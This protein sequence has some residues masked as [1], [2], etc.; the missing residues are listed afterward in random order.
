[1]K[2]QIIIGLGSGRC[3][4]VSL[5]RLLNSQNDSYFKHES[6]PIVPWKFDQKII[7]NKL[8]LLSKKKC[9]Y[10]G[11][12]S[13]S[14]LN[15]MEYI[16]DKFPSAKFVVLKRDR[17][18]VISS[19]IK[20]TS[21]LNLNHWVKHNGE[22]WRKSK[23][24]DDMHPK[25]NI[26]SKEKALGKYWDDYYSK[27]ED[28]IKKYPSNIKIFDTVSLNSK[29]RVEEIL[30]FC[31]VLEEDKNILIRIRENRNGDFWRKLKYFFWRAN[32]L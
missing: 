25:Y 8:A 2:K 32:K 12:I 9:K 18:E 16:L 11:D 21:F 4:T 5:Y 24:W 26:D 7:D 15:Y 17:E 28:L 19:F 30:N 1:M 29:K 10:I 6:Q 20:H 27:V 14:Y 3:G 23:R 13:S 31:D 22:K